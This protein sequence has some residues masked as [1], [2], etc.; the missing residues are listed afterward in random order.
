MSLNKTTTPALPE[1]RVDLEPNKRCH[2]TEALALYEYLENLYD[3]YYKIVWTQHKPHLIFLQQHPNP[4]Q[5]KKELFAKKINKRGNERTVLIAWTSEPTAPLGIE[6]HSFSCYPNTDTNTWF[7][8]FVYMFQTEF[9]AMLNGKLTQRMLANK[10]TPKPNFC[11]FI[12]HKETT[13]TYPHIQNRM[14]I[15]AELMKYKK[16]LCPSKSMNNVQPPDY[17]FADAYGGD[18]FTDGLVRYLTECKFYIAFEN[19]VSSKLEPAGIR[20]ITEKIIAAFTAGSIPIYSGYCEIAE[21]FNPAAFINAHDFSSHQELIEYIKEVDNSPE[22][23]AAYQ[24]APPILPG[25]PLHDLHPDKMRPIFL[26]L[27]ERALKRSSKPLILQPNLV[28]RRIELTPTQNL[29]R[30]ARR[31]VNFLGRKISR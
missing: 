22:L 13:D 17:L 11:A 16:V 19:S 1:L 28:L 29:T 3:G 7:P 2:P 15:C 25:S 20:F 4:D 30:L 8:D 6:D 12:Y 14:D 23:T 31:S 5:V 18:R 10:R 26:S 27:A 21:L 24:N 9:V